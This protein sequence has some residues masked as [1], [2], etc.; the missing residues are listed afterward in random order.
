MGP[1]HVQELGGFSSRDSSSHKAYMNLMHSSLTPLD[2]NNVC[3]RIH[4][5][6]TGIKATRR[7]EDHGLID[8][9]SMREI[10]R[11][12]DRAWQDLE[13]KKRAPIEQDNVVMRLELTQYVGAWQ[14]R[15]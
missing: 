7:A 3:R 10:W 4:D 1:Y 13:S 2:L 8:A 12:L 11:D 5:V 6:L 9:H 14:V 15:T